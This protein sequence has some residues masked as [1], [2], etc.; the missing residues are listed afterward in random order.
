MLLHI[1]LMIII[2]PNRYTLNTSIEDEKIN[3]GE[4]KKIE[5]K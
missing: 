2:I 4:R 1:I 3:E 5:L